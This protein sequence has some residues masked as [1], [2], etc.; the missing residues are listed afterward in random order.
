MESEKAVEQAFPTFRFG[1]ETVGVHQVESVSVISLGMTLRDYFAGQCLAGRMG[2]PEE[3]RSSDE[4]APLC[5]RM[6][7]AMLTAR[8]AGAGRGV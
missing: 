6:A 7:D 3:V 5:Y 8:C 2:N 4:L 1:S